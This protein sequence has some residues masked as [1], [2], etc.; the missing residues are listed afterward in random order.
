MNDDNKE[1]EKVETTTPP[2]PEETNEEDNKQ[3]VDETT[4]SPASEDE[5]NEIDYKAELEKTKTRLNQAEHVIQEQKKKNKP[6]AK[7]EEPEFK[8]VDPNAADVFIS[9]KVQEGIDAY[10]REQADET[11]TSIIDSLSSNQDEKELIRHIY[12]NRIV[13][14]GYTKK[15]ILADLEEAQAIANKKALVTENKELKEALKSKNSTGN[16]SRGTNQDKVDKRTVTDEDRRIADKFFGG[17]IDRYLK[18]KANN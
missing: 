6:D 18:H 1:I 7:V 8:V 4:K 15:D 5:S 16:T 11:I 14:S 10:K 12:D 13:K 2:A 3:E 9:K 17:D